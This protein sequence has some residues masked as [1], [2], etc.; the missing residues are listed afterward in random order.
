MFNK[1]L[2]KYLYNKYYKNK[3]GMGCWD[4]EKIINVKYFFFK[5]I[6]FVCEIIKLVI[7]VK[8]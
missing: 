1:I 2:L 6:Y 7:S 8:Q 5:K 3:D 4:R